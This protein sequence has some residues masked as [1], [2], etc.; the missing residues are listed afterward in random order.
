MFNAI[1]IFSGIYSKIADKFKNYVVNKL[2]EICC[3]K[4]GNCYLTHF[5]ISQIVICQ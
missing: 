2:K 5:E 3:M 4:V 1:V